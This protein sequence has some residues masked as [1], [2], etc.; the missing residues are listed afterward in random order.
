MYSGNFAKDCFESNLVLVLI[1]NA[2][3]V[4]FH[5][6][7]SEFLLAIRYFDFKLQTAVNFYAGKHKGDFLEPHIF[8]E[9]VIPVQSS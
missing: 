3:I 6:V 5:G 4:P 8:R 7:Y 1:F 2:R 9:L